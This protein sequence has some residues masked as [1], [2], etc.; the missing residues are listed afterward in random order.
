[1]SEPEPEPITAWMYHLVR[2]KE[3]EV[4]VAIPPSDVARWHKVTI[5]LSHLLNKRF[6]GRQDGCPSPKELKQLYAEVEV[7]IDEFMVKMD[8]VH[9]AWR[10]KLAQRK[11]EASDGDEA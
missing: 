7:L 2:K 3:I 6:D 1:M 10:E 5:N 8:A 9:E 4:S 11:N